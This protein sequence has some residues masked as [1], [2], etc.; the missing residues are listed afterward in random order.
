[1]KDGKNLG[2]LFNLGLPADAHVS[3]EHLLVLQPRLSAMSDHRET[4]SIPVGCFQH[5]LAAE[6]VAQLGT[7]AVAASSNLTVRK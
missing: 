3:F 1:M 4:G 7:V 5:K 2:G 6:D